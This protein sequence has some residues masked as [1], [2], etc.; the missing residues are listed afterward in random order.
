MYSQCKFLEVFFHVHFTTVKDWRVWSTRAA[1]CYN[2]PN[3]MTIEHVLIHYWHDWFIANCM[4]CMQFLW[5]SLMFTDGAMHMGP[6]VSCS[7]NVLKW[8]SIRVFCLQWN[9]CI[10]D[11]LGP[12]KSVQIIKVSWFSR[13]VYMIMYHLGPQLG[14]WIM[15]VSTFSRVLINRFHCI[16]LCCMVLKGFASNYEVSQHIL[17]LNTA[18]ESKWLNRIIC[19]MYLSC[20]GLVRISM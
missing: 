11:T 10:M 15:Q 17:L 8:E 5:G 20:S 16:V 2:S 9:L 1:L 18:I 14:V 6:F 13:S 3:N 19:I 4:N 7:A 12:A